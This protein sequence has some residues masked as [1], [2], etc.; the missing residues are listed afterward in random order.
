IMR[1][2]VHTSASMVAVSTNRMCHLVASGAIKLPSNVTRTSNYIV[3]SNWPDALYA[4]R[5]DEAAV[6]D[7]VLSPDRIAAHYYTATGVGA[8]LNRGNAASGRDA[9]EL[10]GANNVTI[11]NL[12]L[13]GAESG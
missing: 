11:R 6:Y 5:V 8:T 1:H 3:K 10:V 12:Q 7:K 9:I 13:T 2:V 4:G